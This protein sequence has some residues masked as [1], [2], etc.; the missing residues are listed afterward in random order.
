MSCFGDYVRIKN[1]FPEEVTLKLNQERVVQVTWN[2]AFLEAGIEIPKGKKNHICF[3]RYKQ[4]TWI[5][6]TQK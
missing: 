5:V 2:R 4:S 1:N 3:G 6:S